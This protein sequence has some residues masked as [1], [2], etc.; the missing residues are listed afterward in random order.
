[1]VIKSIEFATEVVNIDNNNIGVL[2][3]SED[4]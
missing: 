4:G 3:K 2:V 1:M